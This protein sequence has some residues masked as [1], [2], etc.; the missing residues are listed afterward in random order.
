MPHRLDLRRHATDPGEIGV[1]EHSRMLNMLTGVEHG[2]R[3]R[4][5]AGINAVV[6]EYYS[7]LGQPLVRRKAKVLRQLSRTEVALLVG[8]NEQDVERSARDRGTF[9]PT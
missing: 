8:K 1:I 6:L 7:S 3:R 4:T 5:H 2:T 9:C